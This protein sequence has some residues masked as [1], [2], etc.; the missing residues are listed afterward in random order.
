MR[1]LLRRELTQSLD[2]RREWPVK[3]QLL[4]GLLREL[5]FELLTQ[6]DPR[7]GSEC[8]TAFRRIPGVLLD[9]SE[10]SSEASRDEDDRSPG[11]NDTLGRTTAVRDTPAQSRIHLR[12]E[13]T[14]VRLRF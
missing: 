14:G 1:W 4:D 12:V 6:E 8:S 11:K 9:Q 5:S 3:E 7:V 2:P 13:F 10:D